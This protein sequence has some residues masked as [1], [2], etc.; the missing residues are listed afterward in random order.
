MI[1]SSLYPITADAKPSISPA[2]LHIVV[3]LNTPFELQCRGVKAMQWQRE[4]RPRVRGEKKIDGMSTLYIP[5]AQPAHMGRYICLE[6]SSQQRTSIYVYVKGRQTK[7]SVF[8]CIC[9]RLS[10]IEVF[11]CERAERE[12]KSRARGNCCLSLQWQGAVCVGVFAGKGVCNLAQDR[13]SRY[14]SYLP[15]A[16]LSFS[17]FPPGCN[18]TSPWPSAIASGSY[19]ELI[20]IPTSPSEAKALA[21]FL[22]R[23]RCSIISQTSVLLMSMCS[24]YYT[25]TI[26]AFTTPPPLYR[27]LFR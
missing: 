6:E 22:H 25:W 4:E 19:H 20:T 11:V 5:K 14:W 1:D 8:E 2:G 27:Y 9:M 23:L 21:S 3:L 17:V 24:V 7:L 10:F 12:L 18:S 13:Y 16:L 26:K 15:S